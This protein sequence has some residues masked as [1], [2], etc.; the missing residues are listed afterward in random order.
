MNDFEHNNKPLYAPLSEDLI[1]Y[2]NSINT[3][4][5]AGHNARFDNI[6]L[7]V[8]KGMMGVLPDYENNMPTLLMVHPPH[9]TEKLPDNFD[10][11]QNWPQCPTI[12]EIRDQ[13]SC[14]SCWAFG[15]VESISDRICI[16]S[17]GSVNAHISAEDLISCCKIICGFGCEGGFPGMAWLYWVQSGLVSG[18]NYNTDQGCRPYTVASC[19]HHTNGTLPPCGDIVHTPKC[20][21][22]CEKGYNVSYKADKHK[23][24]KH[25]SL[26]RQPEQIMAEIM[27]N[28]PVEGAFTVYADFV[29]Y[30]S[31]VYKHETG[32][33]LGGHAI[34]V[35]GWG[36][37]SNTPYW[38]VANSWNTA[39]GNNGLFKI[40]R[41]HN[42]CGIESGIVAGIPA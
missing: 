42:E 20:E 36:V 33:A 12:Q 31:G 34:R 9:V 13:G 14:G 19:E 22:Q 4:W 39:W 18:G 17:N 28:G 11:R 29:S 10:A 35:L 7:H 21:K 2:V 3:T 25:Y 8:I 27:T 41:G 23:G 38:L 26:S 30:K 1:N 5:R 32:A 24:Q 16:H 37:E 40:Y 6:P 15:A